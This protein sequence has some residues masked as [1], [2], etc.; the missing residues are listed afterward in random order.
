MYCIVLMIAYCDAYR[1]PT[2]V[3]SSDLCAFFGQ[4]KKTYFSVCV[5]FLEA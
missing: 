5:H 3:G 2:V 4:R 1:I